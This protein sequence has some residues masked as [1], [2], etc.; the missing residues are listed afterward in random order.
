M[1]I[2]QS[3][4]SKSSTSPCSSCKTRKWRESNPVRYCYQS[5]KDN[6]K[7]RGIEFSLTF[8]EFSEFCIETDYL[9]GKGKTKDSFSI[10]RRDPNEGYVR[11]NIRIL[12]LGENASKRR[13]IL[14]Y[15]DD[16]RSLKVKNVIKRK[17]EIDDPF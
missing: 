14:L 9:I 3:C 4:W 15:D 16:T 1:V 13:K 7:R 2:C 6:S 11:S 5:L 17:P 10:D 12:T 8:E